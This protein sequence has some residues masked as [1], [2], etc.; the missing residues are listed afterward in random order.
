MFHALYRSGE[1]EPPATSEQMLLHVAK[2]GPKAAP[3]VADVAERVQ[4][5]TQDQFNL[6]WPT[7]AGR[8]V[9]TLGQ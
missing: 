8:A 5:L 1:F 7:Q 9:R 4:Q 6:A 3:F 2:D